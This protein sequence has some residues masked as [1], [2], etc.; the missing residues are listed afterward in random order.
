MKLI[1]LNMTIVM[2]VGI[3]QIG[4]AQKTKPG[5]RSPIQQIFKTKLAQPIMVIFNE[6]TYYV[7]K[8]MWY[9]KK[10]TIYRLIKAPVGAPLKTLP[11]GTEEITSNDTLYY[12]YKNTFYKKEGTRYVVVKI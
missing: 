10:K 9:A 3:I 7:E 12:K 2:L 8:G 1:K 6:Q 4:Y 5:M 11:E